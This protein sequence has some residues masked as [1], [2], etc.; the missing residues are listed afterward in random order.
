MV[1]RQGAS[2]RPNGM[3]LAKYDALA[4]G[5]WTPRRYSL[6]RCGRIILTVHR[7]RRP[8]FRREARN[9]EGEFK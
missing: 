3:N 4:K 5:P 2:I 1:K 9:E 6:Y 8:P 7:I